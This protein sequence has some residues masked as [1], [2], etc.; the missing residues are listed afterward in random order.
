MPA[1]WARLGPNRAR[2]GEGAIAVA[3]KKWRI[4][5][6]ERRSQ[7]AGK[8][9]R[10][11]PSLRQ[12]PFRMTAAEAEG[13]WRLVPLHHRRA[14]TAAGSHPSVTVLASQPSR[15]PRRPPS[16]ANKSE[17]RNAGKKHRESETTAR[18]FFGDVMRSIG[19]RY[20]ALLFPISSAIVLST[21]S[22]W[23]KTSP[24]QKR[25]TTYPCA[26]RY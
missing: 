19:N 20:G 15:E 21:A 6:R 4:R 3:A 10:G 18:P 23:V 17:R 5:S 1:A 26:S 8:S 14:R 7:R 22:R 24:F 25:R 12:A 2:F 11:G 9:L 13:A 16:L